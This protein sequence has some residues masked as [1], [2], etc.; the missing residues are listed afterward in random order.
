[1][2]GGS[3]ALDDAAPSVPPAGEAA[4]PADAAAEEHY[5]PARDIRWTR[6]RVSRIP[7]DSPAGLAIARLARAAVV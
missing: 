7:A 3:G 2:S 4:A 5:Q 1:M 6:A